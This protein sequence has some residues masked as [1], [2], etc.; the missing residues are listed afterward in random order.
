VND[1]HQVTH[2]I[3]KTIH[4]VLFFNKRRVMAKVIVQLFE[5]LVDKSYVV[6]FV[7]YFLMYELMVNL[8]A[9]H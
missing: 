1:N 8:K 9:N 6:V 2:H 7:K 3:I 5:E 4:L